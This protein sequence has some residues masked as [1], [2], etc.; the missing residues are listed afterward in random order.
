METMSRSGFGN[1]GGGD[2]GGDAGGEPFA[3]AAAA[4][5]LDSVRVWGFV[6]CGRVC[7]LGYGLRRLQ[8]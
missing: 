5:G 8:S 4:A 7:S 1:G 6:G 3:A 2:G